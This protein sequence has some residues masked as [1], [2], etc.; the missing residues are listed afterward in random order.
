ME[1]LNYTILSINDKRADKKAEI[2]RII[3][4]AIPEIK[5][6][7][8][9]GRDTDQVKAWLT[10]APPINPVWTRVL[11]G[12]IGVW[13]SQIN[14][15]R[16]IVRTDCPLL[17]LEDD[18]ILEE[19]FLEHLD[20]MLSETPSTYDF[21]S[22]FVP[23]N[24]EG[25]YYLEVGYDSEGKALPY[26]MGAPEGAPCFQI[27]SEVMVKVYQG[28]SC[29][30]TIV[31]PKGAARLLELAKTY[32]IYTPVDCFYFLNAH[33]GL[34]EGYAPQPK[35]KRVVKIDWDAPTEIHDTGYINLV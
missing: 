22:V 10:I 5:V 6:V 4:D 35:F 11:H 24:Q 31:S 28:Y 8:V 14:A 15:W 17:I 30:A 13:L 9:N 2:R 26:G 20:I 33:R 27:G 23:N 18:A 32:G 16:K 3:G 7:C 1:A 29:V 12:E 25:D 19:D 34:L 21:I